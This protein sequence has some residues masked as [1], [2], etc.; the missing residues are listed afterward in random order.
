MDYK[1]QRLMNPGGDFGWILGKTNSPAVLSA[2]PPEPWDDTF[3]SFLWKA[4]GESPPRAENPPPELWGEQEPPLASPP[5]RGH[6][7][8]TT[9][10]VL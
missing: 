3:Q 8:G 2:S 1:P 6:G 5:W 10:D 9:R 4:A 7:G